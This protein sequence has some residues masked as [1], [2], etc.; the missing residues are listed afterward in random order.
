MKRR[1]HNTDGRRQVQLG[2]TREQVEHI[3]LRLGIPMH[4]EVLAQ[5]RAAAVLLKQEPEDY[6]DA[7]DPEYGL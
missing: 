6:P 1:H 5:A 3:A 7:N 4:A 2:R